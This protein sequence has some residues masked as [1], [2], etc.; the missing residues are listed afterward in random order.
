[1]DVSAVPLFYGIA[2]DDRAEEI[3]ANLAETVHDAGGTLQTGFLGTRALIHALADHG[4][5]ET[6]YEVVTQP[7]QPGWVYMVHNGA[8]TIWERWDG[9]EQVG[10][11]MNSLN[12]PSFT[13]VSE[14]F[15]RAL[16]GIRFDR[17]FASDRRITVDPT[18]PDDLDW[19]AGS[20]ETPY[21]TVSSR[22]EQTDDTLTL[23]VE[24]PWN[25]TAAVRVPAETDGTV[26]TGDVP[27][28]DG[29]PVPDLPDG[30]HE[31]FAEDDGVTVVVESGAHD[32]L[33][34]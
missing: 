13:V 24:V 12:H 25:V 32:V 9:D 11:G 29:G 26:R 30:V 2:P 4:Q 15:Y 1:V 18:V 34:E 8:T 14:W 31:V 23:R 7:D 33:V 19:A 6:A 22:W 21:G 27:V 28:W 3:A 20:V 16:A 5:I 17:A 10:S